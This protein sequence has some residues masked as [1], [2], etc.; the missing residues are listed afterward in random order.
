MDKDCLRISGL[1]QT[2]KVLR[3][4][5]MEITRSEKEAQAVSH[6]IPGN[7]SFW[8]FYV[9]DPSQCRHIISARKPEAFGRWV[10]MTRKQH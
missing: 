4:E 9:I 6:V 5:L 8:P 10:Q 2:I 1:T 3:F 7:F